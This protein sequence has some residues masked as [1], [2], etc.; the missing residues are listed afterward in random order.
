MFRKESV[1]FEVAVRTRIPCFHFQGRARAGNQLD[2]PVGDP[3][4]SSWNTADF[5]ADV[6]SW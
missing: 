6:S 5:Y 3:L 2:A 4:R 1:C